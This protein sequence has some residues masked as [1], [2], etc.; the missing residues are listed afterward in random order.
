MYI[1]LSYFLTHLILLQRVFWNLNSLKLSFRNIWG[2]RSNFFVCKSFLE[3]NSPDILALC[4][5]ILDGSIDSGNFSVRSYLLLFQK[6]SSTHM[7][8]LAVYVEEGVSFD[9][10]LE[11]SA[12][13]YLCL[14]H[15][16][17]YSFFLYWSPS[18]SLCS[19]CDSISFNIDEVL[20]INPSAN[21]FV[22]GDLDVD[23]K[24]CLTYS[25][26]TAWPGELC[27]NFHNLR[28]PGFDLTGHDLWFSTR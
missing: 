18:L 9:L 4:E 17:S 12:D 5:T 27:Y 26:G 3:S 2:L 13:F 21:V 7:H 22:F 20:S 15:S 24:D 23:Q 14:L 25:G 16:R 1:A 19:V 11:K 28:W 10:S 6:Y 8:G